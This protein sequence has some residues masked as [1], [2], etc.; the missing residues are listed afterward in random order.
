[1][2]VF[3][4]GYRRCEMPLK[5]HHKEGVNRR[6]QRSEETLLE[7]AQRIQAGEIGKRE[8]ERYCGVPVRN[9]CRRIV[10]AKFKRTIHGPQGALGQA[11]EKRLFKH[12]Q[13]LGTARFQLRKTYGFAQ[14]L[15]V[16]HKVPRQQ[17]MGV[18][19]WLSSFLE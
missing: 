1:M 8:A 6:D 15:G 16:S 14:E 2:P 3:S 10:T 18:S 17:E 19:V 7:A 13:R 5:Y 4:S 11:N 12:I 9:L